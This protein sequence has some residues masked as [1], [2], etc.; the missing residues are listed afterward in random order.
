MSFVYKKIRNFLQ[1][2]CINVKECLS[3]IEKIS[4]RGFIGLGSKTKFMKQKNY[5]S[6]LPKFFIPA[7]SF[8][9][10]TKTNAQNIFPSTGAVG[11]GTTTPNASSLLEIKSTT[12]GVLIPRMTLTQRNAIASPAQGLMIF[13][14]NNT[15]GFYYYDGTAWKSIAPKTN[16]S[17]TGNAGTNASTNFIGT[18][19]AQP[20]VFKVN[21]TRAGYI[22]Y[23]SSKANTSFGHQSLVSNTTGIYNAAVGYRSLFANTK[24]NQNTALG[25]SAL[26][27]N[28]TGYSNTGIGYQALFTNISSIGNTATGLWA[29]YSTTSSIDNTA[30]GIQ[31]L[32]HNTSGGNNTACGGG[33]LITN[34]IGFSNSGFGFQ[35]LFTNSTGSDNTALGNSADVSADGFV[36][37]TALGDLAIANASYKVVVGPN[38]GGMVIGGYAPWSNLSDGR[39]KENVKEDVPGL[40]F[41]TKLHPITYTINTKKLDEH[42]MQNMPDSIK[43]KRMQTPDQYAKAATKIQTGFIAQEVEKTAKEMGYDFDGVNAPK[44]NTDN[45]SI[46]Y[47]QF[48]VPLVKAVQ[49]LSAKNDDLQKQINDLKATIVSSQSSAINQQSAIISSASL[50]QNIPNPFSNTT[51][52]NYTLPQ[53]FEKLHKL[54]LLIKMVKQLKQ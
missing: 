12:K 27:N 42:V 7:L 37:A 33:A 35:A 24:G 49:E 47:S 20:L 21:N 2:S 34:T 5:L 26:Y 51:S 29:L 36:Y 39:F 25:Y 17:L 40:K 8:F 52:I 30:N 23:D 14:T 11:I 54:L 48:V 22:E 1:L 9:V 53:K 13:Q 32:Y 10:L 6:L 19:D 31:A 15:A 46:A 28:T 41:I 38:I 3:E 50:E 45:Y 4:Y 16:W 44:N 43:A 18:I